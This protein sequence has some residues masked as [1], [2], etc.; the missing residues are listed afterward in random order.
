MA[1]LDKWKAEEQLQVHLFTA[2]LQKAIDDT[3]A[4]LMAEARAPIM[5][6]LAGAF[7]SVEAGFMAGLADARSAKLMRT[8]MDK[9]R[10]QALA[11]ARQRRQ[12]QAQVVTVGGRTHG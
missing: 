2:A 9:A 8:A 5:N 6:A 10:P 11:L 12:G 3:A 4:G 7:V 1:E